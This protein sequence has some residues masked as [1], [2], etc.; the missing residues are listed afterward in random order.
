MPHLVT[1]AD[2]TYCFVSF[3]QSEWERKDQHVGIDSPEQFYSDRSRQNTT[4]NKTPF[5][6]SHLLPVVYPNQTL[7]SKPSHLL[8]AANQTF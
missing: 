1:A 3:V 7:Y 2:C 5:I 8:S 6:L 4:T